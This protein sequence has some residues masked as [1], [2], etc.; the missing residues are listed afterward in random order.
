L[1]DGISAGETILRQDATRRGLSTAAYRKFLAKRFRD[2]EDP[3]RYIAFS[4]PE[5]RS[6]NQ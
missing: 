5:T 6:S 2:V 1:Q 4:E 3:H